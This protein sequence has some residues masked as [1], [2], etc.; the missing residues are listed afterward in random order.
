MEEKQLKDFLP[1]KKSSYLK[2]F[3]NTNLIFTMPNSDLCINVIF[4]MIKRN[5]CYTSYYI[6]FYKLL[7][8]IRSKHT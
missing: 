2:K 8:V 1:D 4:K 3:N 7:P 6:L 5:K